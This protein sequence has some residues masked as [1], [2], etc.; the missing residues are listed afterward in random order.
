MIDALRVT[1]VEGCDEE[2]AER[3][4]ISGSVGVALASDTLDNAGALIAAA[5]RAM[6]DA[7]RAGRDRYLVSSGPAVL[8]DDELTIA[9]V[10]AA[11]AQP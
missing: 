1:V 9:H 3:L 2:S 4:C 10:A 6:Y 8:D 11:V 5:D 7:K